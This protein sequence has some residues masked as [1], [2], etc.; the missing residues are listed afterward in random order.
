MYETIELI[1][2]HA[3][4]LPELAKFAV[5]MVIIVGV[6]PLSRWARVPDIVGFLLSGVLIG[7]YVFDLA[8]KHRPVADFA[9]ELGKLL[10]MFF[11][12]LE[13]NLALF[14]RAQK[15]AVSFGLL[16]T[17]I[18][19]SLGTAVGFWWGY[20]LI[21]AVVLGSL[22]A[23]HTLL[24]SSIVRRLGL[25]RLEP[26]TVTIGATVLSDTL[27]LIVFA[28]CVSTYKNGFSPQ[29]LGV[30]LVEI[31]VFFPVVLFGLS[32]LGGYALK[33]LEND[34]DAYFVLMFVILA[35]AG[36]LAR[37]IDLP[38][39]VGAFL[40]GLA[41]NAAVHDKPA[42]EKLEFIGNSVFI[43]IFFIVTGFLI[44]P[45]V[46]VQSIVNNLPLALAVILA[47]I[48]GKFVAA[49][50]AGRAFNYS[51][52]AR[53]TVW[54]LTLPQV[55]ATLAATLTA[56]AT[57]NPAGQRLIDRELLNVVLVL[58]LTTSILGPILTA[59]FAQRMIE[60]E[61]AEPTAP[62]GRVA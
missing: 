26:I 16:T 25:T 43:P 2:A 52:N 12:G 27:S 33:K 46:F 31:A 40:A 8:G 7:P 58:M 13:I 57:F 24:A 18:P 11:C 53:K 5:V 59:H 21:P 34:E 4:A 50:I 9:A 51:S 48:T 45:R 56:F 41:V 6:P 39:I 14:R 61:A 62:S 30:Q 44:N 15:R 49:Q 22:L 17:L 23:S 28:I 1:R 47:L 38:D 19:L 20:A 42:K 29:A 10:L 3:S 60:D 55:A 37:I 36:L 54:S 35:V 32:R